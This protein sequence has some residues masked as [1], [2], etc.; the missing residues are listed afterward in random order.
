LRGVDTLTN[1][2]EIANW[3][4]NNA[5]QPN[6]IS[7]MKL[8]KLLYYAQGH[9]LVR[10]DE[11]LFE[12]DF[13][14]WTH[15]PVIPEIYHK[16]SRYNSLPI[17]ERCPLSETFSDELTALLL[18]VYCAYGKYTAVT[19]SAQTHRPDTPWAITARGG[20]IGVPSIRLY[21]NTVVPRLKSLSESLSKRNLPQYTLMADDYDPNEDA[22][23][24]ALL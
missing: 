2:F 8:N 3:F 20:I 10:F 19:L 17:T 12:N 23:W 16:Y 4:L 6:D 15:G 9:A 22:I 11:P 13:M 24:E 7:N 5:E 21:F 1:V 14:A 18:D